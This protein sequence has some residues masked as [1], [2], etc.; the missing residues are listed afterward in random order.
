MM[1]GVGANNNSNGHPKNMMD[2]NSTA[3]LCAQSIPWNVS[4][5]NYY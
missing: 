1:L 3:A 5:E 2:F 4:G